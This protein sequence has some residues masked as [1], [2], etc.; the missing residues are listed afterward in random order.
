MGASTTSP[1]I[2]TPT[3]APTAAITTTTAP[4][5]SA[6]HLQ[7][8]LQQHHA[9]KR[10]EQE[11]KE[12]LE[13]EQRL[14]QQEQSGSAGVSSALSATSAYSAS[15]SLKADAQSVAAYMAAYMKL[16]DRA[17]NENMASMIA[18]LS[19]ATMSA[20]SPTTI[21]PS[22]TMLYP[23]PSSPIVSL[24]PSTSPPSSLKPALQQRKVL[25][26]SSPSN[27]RKALLAVSADT[28]VSSSGSAASGAPASAS[29]SITASSDPVSATS[30][31]SQPLLSQQQHRQECH[32]CGVTKTPLWRRTQDRKHSL[33]NACG[34]Y[35]KQYKTNRPIAGPGRPP[36]ESLWLQQ[37]DT[38]S[39]SSSSQ[40]EQQQTKRRKISDAAESGSVPV[41]SEPADS[42]QH[43]CQQQNKAKVSSL[44]HLKPLLPHPSTRND[45]PQSSF[46]TESYPSSLSHYSASRQHI[47]NV[48]EEPIPSGSNESEADDEGGGDMD[49]DNVDEDDTSDQ[50]RQYRRNFDKDI[51]MAESRSDRESH[52][53]EEDDNSDDSDYGEHQ[54]QQQQQ[55]HRD[56][57][58]TSSKVS[59]LTKKSA[60]DSVLLLPKTS[61]GS[62]NNAN[63][64]SG[65]TP[66]AV[67]CA[68][69]GQTQ[70]PLWRKDAKGRS[71]C[72][73]CGLYARLHQRDRPVTMRKT[74]IA[75]RKRDWKASQEKAAA[76][77]AAVSAVSE[78]VGTAQAEAEADVEASNTT[79]KSSGGRKRKEKEVVMNDSH[80]E[81]RA[82]NIPVNMGH[83]SDESSLCLLEHQS[84]E[85]H[86]LPTPASNAS[87]SPVMS[88]PPRSL[89]LSSLSLES[90]GSLSPSLTAS[91]PT[92][93]QTPH[94]L[95]TNN[96]TS[97]SAS[98]VF[99]AGLNPL[100]IQQYQQH[101]QNQAALSAA[102][103]AAA[104]SAAVSGATTPTSETLPM[105]GNSNISNSWLAQLYP[106]YGPMAPFLHNAGMPRNP[107]AELQYQQ[108]QRQGQ[109]Q[110]PFHQM[111]AS[112][113]LS[114]VSF[115]DG[116]PS[117]S[118]T[119]PNPIITNTQ[120]L[121]ALQRQQQQQQQQ[122]L[123]LQQQQ[124]NQQKK[125]QGPLILD[126]TRFTRLMNQMSKPQL[127]MFLTILEERCGALRHRL[128]GEDDHVGRVDTNEM[129]MMLNTPQFTSM[130]AGIHGVGGNSGNCSS[131]HMAETSASASLLAAMN[132]LAHDPS[133]QDTQHSYQN[134]QHQSDCLM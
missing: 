112:S 123:T 83:E 68:N 57:D 30:T 64:S 46:R 73:A 12:R 109:Q 66:P 76:A 48:P 100:L 22:S 35:F 130:E 90:G 38:T 13:Q 89:T 113:P 40:Q 129:M 11:A 25:S 5:P 101:L 72:N 53:S 20:P 4:S 127:S 67:E 18:T 55:Q 49:Q 21:A 65:G 134:H 87:L 81:V 98:T 131:N 2:L 128:S 107:L 9:L 56:E 133:G 106:Q 84:T 88:A 17:R 119:R 121:Q 43:P 10:K 120:T 117:F 93:V 99:P 95:D 42:S 7:L 31:K 16:A 75:R 105:L 71:I 74:K 54:Q 97:P 6:A 61:S 39:V 27:G 58:S 50:Q 34:L 92:P 79:G 47:D 82:M 94:F 77:A 108:Q 85:D 122:K 110:V 32:N 114:P 69:C 78:I 103:T 59:S 52:D 45:L 104:V 118:S 80:V 44:S 115:T 126:S 37:V 14:L 124:Q 33:C 3:P 102:A 23:S 28:S 24:I 29:T 8:L 132:E 125:G 51:D 86:D 19:S 1:S 96:S 26:K 111:K 91:P 116:L 15:S 62:N 70:T 41:K 60:P 36:I 63:K